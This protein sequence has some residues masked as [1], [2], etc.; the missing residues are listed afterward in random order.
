L[1]IAVGGNWGG[2]EGIDDL[3]WPQQMEVDWV[4]VY[5]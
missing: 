4:R 5:Q 3:I 1:N 2:K